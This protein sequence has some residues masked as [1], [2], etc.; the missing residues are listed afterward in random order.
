ML[1]EAAVWRPEEARL[2]ARGRLDR[3]GAALQVAA[4]GVAQ[5]VVF[6]VP[7]AVEGDLMPRLR[8]LL[9][10]VG[11]RRHL[12]AHEEEH[13]AYGGSRQGIE[14]GGRGIRVGPVVEGERHPVLHMLEGGKAPPA[15]ERVEV[16]LEGRHRA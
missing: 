9:R 7:E 3:R 6:D 14:D 2:D 8:H 11:V 4:D 15:L 10:E 13:R 16:L 5:L 1:A 12:F